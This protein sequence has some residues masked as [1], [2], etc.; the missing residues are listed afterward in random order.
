MHSG[1]AKT[2]I[3]TRRVYNY[4]GREGTG[5]GRGEG[6]G[7]RKLKGGGERI[8]RRA[9][10]FILNDYV[11]DYKIRLSILDL[12]PLFELNDI[13]FCVNILKS[14]TRGFNIH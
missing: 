10:K 14:P 4:R 9:T 13:L 6:S 3:A 11:S 2:T 8:Q 12:L 7:N 1:Q 5:E